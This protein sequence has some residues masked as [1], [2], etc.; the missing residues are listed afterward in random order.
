MSEK[1]V[2]AAECVD[3]EGRNEREIAGWQERRSAARGID[4][5]SVDESTQGTL[6]EETDFD[7]PF[8]HVSPHR[9]LRVAGDGRL[10][11]TSPFAARREGAGTFSRFTWN[12]QCIDLYPVEVSGTG[13]LALTMAWR[14]LTLAGASPRYFN[15]MRGH[16]S[17]YHGKMSQSPVIRSGCFALAGG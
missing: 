2:I 7:Q 4:W 15:W 14:F 8:P 9:K 17:L 11:R 6:H 16:P 13:T 1:N 10:C 5:R 12:P 3:G